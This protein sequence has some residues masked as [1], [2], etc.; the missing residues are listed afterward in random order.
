M[1]V[2]PKTYNGDL[3]NPPQALTPLIIC[4]RW[5]IWRWEQAQNGN[6]TKPPY[7]ATAPGRHAAN[8][9]PETWRPYKDAMSAVHAGRAH[10]IGFALDGGDYA[11]IDLDKC[12]NPETGKIDAWAQDILDR[13]PGAYIEVTVSGTGLRVIG[14]AAG[15]EA[16]RKFAVSGNAA[17]E[18]YRKA[19]RYITISF[20]QIGECTELTNIDAVID[21]VIETY[22]QPAPKVEAPPLFNDVDHLIENGA[23]EGQRS[24]NFA[25]VVWSLAG[26]GLTREEIEQELRA[27]P[28]GIAAKYLERDRLAAEIDRCFA[29][30]TQAQ[31]GSARAPAHDWDD[32]DY[33]VLEDKRG[34][35]PDFPL[36]IFSEDWQAWATNAAHGA[37]TTVDHVLVL[38]LGV[39]SS[40]VGTARRA[41]ASK[42]WSEPFTLWTCV[43]GFSGTGKTPGIDVTKRCL[44]KIEQDRRTRIHELRR[45]HESKAEQARA[46]FKAWKTAVQEALNKKQ[47]SPPM[48]PDADVPPD[49]VEPRLHISNSTVEKIAVLLKV[50]P[51]G[52][53]MIVDELAGL[54][55]NLARYSGGS[56]REFWLEAW[57]G[58]YYVVERMGREPVVLNHLLV[59]MTGGF[60][61]DKLNSSFGGAADGIYTRM[62][63]AW[64]PEPAY[65]KLTDHVEEIEPEL[66]N[67]LTRLIDLPAEQ[68]DELLVSPVSLSSDARAAFEDFR[69]YVHAEKV[70]LDAHDR[71]WWAKAPTHV[72]RLSGTLAYLDWARRTAGKPVLIDEPNAIEARFVNA[73][74]RLVR[75]Y[76]WPHARAALRQIGLT[77]RHAKT[78]RVL[79]WLQANG[80]DQVSREDVRRE[81]LSRHLDAEETQKV[82]DALERTGWLKKV[83]TETAGRAKHRWLVNPKLFS[84]AEREGREGREGLAA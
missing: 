43:I 56:D 28:N 46:V 79:R 5:L 59:G 4:S 32:P 65:Q 74:V 44:T 42:S 53:L 37:G 62:L 9:N 18:V 49:F 7:L 50:R 19:T 52:M 72:L 83:T 31:S 8:N 45:V 2:F 20:M 30:R 47:P 55:L 25:R 38:L 77:E 26:Q 17:V 16:H 35:L 76:F 82:I 1:T 78:R 33:S 70:A 48:P 41:K 67:T 51:R 66:Y 80:R 27:R 34:D 39:A 23:P 75:D 60:Q 73:A 40:L 69:K 68:D 57:N 71:E 6:W 11:V 36:D 22:G 63:F 84:G 10:G 61:P 13:A 3:A 21:C 24:E 29:K 81:A 54:F 64:P 15:A 58:K 14:V 12:R